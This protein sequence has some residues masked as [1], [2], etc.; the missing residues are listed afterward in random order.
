M[1]DV[2]HVD[3]RDRGVGVGVGREQRPPRAREQVHRL[4]EELDAAHLR[5]AIVR[6]QDSD[7]RPAQLQVTQG[8]HRLGSRG[9]PYDSV[10]LAVLAAQVPRHRPR[11]GRVVVDGEQDGPV[12]GLGLAADGRQVQ[13]LGHGCEK[14]GR[15]PTV[16][17]S[18]SS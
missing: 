9:R 10:V 18:W 17:P 8:V 7:P 3:G 5:H 11:H 2:D 12:G 4:L 16:K 15:S 1:V 6:Q 14:S 13:V